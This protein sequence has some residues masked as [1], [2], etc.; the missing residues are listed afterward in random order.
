M[1]GGA[2]REVILSLLT[3]LVLDRGASGGRVVG[4]TV[5]QG[6]SCS[7]VG[8]FYLTSCG[9]DST[10]DLVYTWHRK[11]AS[12][13]DRLFAWFVVLWLSFQDT[14]AHRTAWTLAAPAFLSSFCPFFV[15]VSF[16]LL[17]PEKL[18]DIL[19]TE[20]NFKWIYLEIF[21]MN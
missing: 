11:R 21:I 14:W 1:R 8:A 10:M 16:L 9:T 6:V 13:L 3:T 15:M 2:H 18:P 12:A 20:I 7:E 4:A 5:V 19:M 17:Y